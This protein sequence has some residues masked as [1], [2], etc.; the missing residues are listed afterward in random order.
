MREQLEDFQHGLQDVEDENMGLRTSVATL[1]E[2]IAQIET[3]YHTFQVSTIEQMRKE[4]ELWEDDRREELEILRWDNTEKARLLETQRAINAQLR[5]VIFGGMQKGAAAGAGAGAMSPSASRGS[6]SEAELEAA[7]MFE[8]P[9]S[10]RS[11]V[12]PPTMLFTEPMSLGQLRDLGLAPMTPSSS[13]PGSAPQ[14]PEAGGASPSSPSLASGGSGNPW[15][16]SSSSPSSRASG[17]LGGALGGSS[18]VASRLL[19]EKQEADEAVSRAL[20]ADNENLLQRLKD[21]ERKLSALEA[22][23]D[24]LRTRLR[25]TEEAVNGLFDAT[26]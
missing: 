1:S 10:P 26:I 2:Q 18:K 13:R 16:A 6:R 17:A 24:A 12:R 23:M 25:Q 9:L 14:S 3:A 15:Q 21:K 5:L 8:L 4:R 20:Q 11:N 19:R 7:E 22:E